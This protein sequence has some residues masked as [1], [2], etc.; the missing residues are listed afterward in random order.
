MDKMGND[1]ISRYRIEKRLGYE[2]QS[3]V[4]K[5]WDEELKRWVAIKSI[6]PVGELTTR[7]LKRA[8]REARA[9]AAISHTAVAQVHDVF[10]EDGQDHM[11][12]EFVEG[13]SLADLLL[14]GPLKLAKALCLGLDVANGLHAA[15][16]QGVIHR[17]LKVDNIMVTPAGRAKILDFGLAKLSGEDSGSGSHSQSDLIGTI[18]AMSPEQIKQR[19]NVDHRSDLFSFGTL[20]YELTA[21]THPFRVRLPWDTITNI[22]EREPVPPHEVNPKVP[23]DVSAMIMRL[24]AKDQKDRPKGI[25]VIRTLERHCPSRVNSDESPRRHRLLAAAVIGIGLVLA[26]IAGAWLTHLRAP[27]EPLFVVVIK[28][29]VESSSTEKLVADGVRMAT[30]N[31]LTSLEAVYPV[32]ISEFDGY[33]GEASEVARELDVDEAVIAQLTREPA[34][35]LEYQVTVRRVGADD[36]RELHS[37]DFAVPV[38]DLRLLN[39]A[40]TAHVRAIYG[41]RSVK[42]DSYLT[43]ASTADYRTYLDV[44]RHF[45]DSAQSVSA[46]ELLERLSKIHESSPGLLDAYALAVAISTQLYLEE[47]D[48]GAIVQAEDAMSRAKELAPDDPRTL[49]TEAELALALNDLDRAQQAIVA[50][51]AIAPVDPVHIML[52]AKLH[53]RQGHFERAIALMA[54]SVRRRPSARQIRELAAMKMRMGKIVEARE[55]LNEGLQRAPDN[56]KLLSQLAELELY[57]GSPEQAE[58]LYRNLAT[59]A[60]D[61]R[62]I[63]G[64]AM[65]KNL[66]GKAEEASEHLQRLVHDGVKLPSTLLILSDSYRLQGKKDQADRV[67]RQLLDQLEGNRV[68]P[69]VAD[70]RC[71]AQCLAYI[72]EADEAE[73]VVSEV[74]RLAP[75]SPVTHYSAAVVYRLIGRSDDAGSCAERALELGLSRSWLPAQANEARL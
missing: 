58:R 28:P 5:A 31:T 56:R 38:D 60:P 18:I 74:L 13:E 15:H 48:T 3:E 8:R 47:H 55:H 67:C 12:M 45:H 24:L 66:L 49:L 14:R 73:A 64:L 39:D 53:E 63:A 26:V 71:Q 23:H 29:E 46:N 52:K 33:Q 50:M 44:L 7:E 34:D 36:G 72:G 20:L 10:T 35:L 69:A 68:D 16:S 19:G 62:T 42:N 75:D 41:E 9:A 61:P 4:F 70:L 11:V 43:Q 57:H 51:E 59:R 40:V 2:G 30:I 22:V 25:D 54:E 27:A 65:A 6:L 21:G 17:D 32:S 37:V 1:S